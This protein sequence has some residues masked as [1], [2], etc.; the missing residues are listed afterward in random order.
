MSSDARHLKQHSNITDELLVSQLR[1]V[2]AKELSETPHMN[3]HWFLTKFI[4]ARNYNMKAV[5]K[6]LADHFKWRRKNNIA[7]IGDINRQK[8]DELKK[9]TERGFYGTDREGRPIWIE[10][11]ALTDIKRFLSSEFNEIREAFLVSLFER[12]GTILLPMASAAAKKPVESMLLICD[13]KGINFLKIFDSNFKDFV[14]FLI[15]MVQDNYPENLGRLLMINVSLSFRS[16]WSIIKF[17]MDKKTISK[18]ELHGGVPNERLR[19]LIDEETIPDFFGGKCTMPLRS[20]WG[21]WKQ[22]LD[23]SFEDRSI[24]LRDRTPEFDYFYTPEERQKLTDVTRSMNFN[25]ER[26][27]TGHSIQVR[28]LQTQLQNHEK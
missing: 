5:E 27:D 22:Q 17:W 6:M 20:N 3:T 18:I 8:M 15:S 2:F 24:F 19:E 14:K 13:L 16:I 21:P 4:R 28:E 11:F 9:I 7:K 10:R 23:Q 26:E 1:T 25:I 12:F